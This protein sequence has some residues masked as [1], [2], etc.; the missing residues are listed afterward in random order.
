MV[1]SL[2][3]SSIYKEYI[4]RG[5]VHYFLINKYLAIT[6]AEIRV[7]SPKRHW[8]LHSHRFPT[9]FL[10]P[11]CSLM[12]FPALTCPLILFP[13]AALTCPLMMFPAEALT[14]PLMLFPAASLTCPAPTLVGNKTLCSCSTIFNKSI[15]VEISFFIDSIASTSAGSSSWDCARKSQ[16]QTQTQAFVENEEHMKQRDELS[17]KKFTLQLRGLFLHLLPR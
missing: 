12:I 11:A 4:W 8:L 6:Q 17:E 14:C 15:V 16:R 2:I 9:C 7:K 5:V 13:A 10:S 1:L 3:Y